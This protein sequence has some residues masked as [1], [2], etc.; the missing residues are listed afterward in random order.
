MKLKINSL[1]SYNVPERCDLLM[2]INAARL[3]NQ[4]IQSE[5]LSVTPDISLTY[6]D[7]EE[8]IG[9]RV[10]FNVEGN[11]E[12]AYKAV[13]EVSREPFELAEAQ[14]KSVASLPS[15]VVK[16]LMPSRY[17][18]P[19]F[20]EEI[21]TTQ[22][23]ALSGGALVLAMSD[24]IH[25][26]FDYVAGASDSD[27]T[28]IDTYIDRQGVCRD[29]AHVLIAMARA[30]AIPARMV[31]AYAPRV[32]PQDFHAVVEVFLDDR[33]HLVDPT[34]M[35][36]AEDIVIIGVGRDAADVSFLTSFG[37]VELIRLSVT[38]NPI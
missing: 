24:W 22:F 8:D 4:I 2:Q 12:F 3:D 33:W 28:A 34:R 25:S 17:C 32:L 20:F 23:G 15:E 19:D 11:F 27:T 1:L 36:A 26:N 6:I 9:S 37:A 30:A 38:V 16:Y 29:Y 35:A 18:N 10:V 13:V 31:S 14:Q 7:A 21:V 5:E